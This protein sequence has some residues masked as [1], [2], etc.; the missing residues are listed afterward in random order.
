MLEHICA[1]IWPRTSMFTT[2]K[3]RLKPE[4]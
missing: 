2:R 1:L 3:H 4:F